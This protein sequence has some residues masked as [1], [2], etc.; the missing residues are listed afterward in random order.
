M[1]SATFDWAIKL[2]YFCE[3]TTSDFRVN[4]KEISEEISHFFKD[5]KGFNQYKLEYRKP[6]PIKFLNCSCKIEYSFMGIYHTIFWM[7]TFLNVFL[8]V[9][10]FLFSNQV[11]IL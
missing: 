10:K 9:A 3:E 2:S 6:K 4:N 5:K 11:S 1:S 8:L 7:F